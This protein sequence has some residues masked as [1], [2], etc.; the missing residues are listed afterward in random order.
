MKD[1]RHQNRLYYS[2]VEFAMNYIGGTWKMPILVALRGGPV[3]YGDL[4]KSISHITDKMLITQLRD[5]EKKNMV[6]R[7]AYAEKP[8]RVDYA[9]TER[10][11]QALSI[12]DA[13]HAYGVVLMK[14]EEI[15][16]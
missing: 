5:L 8:P 3:R 4:K 10:A 7:K 15:T 14:E 16:L 1:F 13:L 6:I 9:L 12:I 11:K 2:P